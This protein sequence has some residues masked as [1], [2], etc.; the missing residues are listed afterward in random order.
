MDQL[1]KKAD[2][3]A[4]CFDVDEDTGTGTT[5]S[6]QI[7]TSR[8]LRKIDCRL[9]PLLGFCYFLQ[10]LDKV[11]LGY[12]AL[13]GIRADVGLVG[14]EYSW[15]TSIFY[16]GYFAW[17]F[18]TT[19]IIVRVPLGKYLSLV[20]FAW[21]AVLACHAAC[22][23]YAGFMVARF[24]LGVMEAS[25]APGFSF[26]TGKFYKRE[27]QPLR[28]GIWFL[29]NS[30]AGFFG[31]LIAYGIGHIESTLYSWQ[32]L[33][34]ILGSLTSASGIAMFFLLPD[35]PETAWFLSPTERVVAVERT[36]SAHQKK[37]SNKFQSYQVWEALKDPQSWLLC[38]NMLGTML[39]NSGFTA[40]TGIIIAGFGYS[41]LQ[42]LLY[43]MPGSA[44]QIGLVTITSLCGSYVPNSRCYMLVILALLS[45]I[46]CVLVYTLDDNHRQTKLFGTSI[47]GSFAAGIPIS[48]SMVSSNVCGSTKK[49]T[50]SAM[51]FI[52]YCVGNIISP[53][54][55]LAREEPKYPTG[56]K[57]CLS[58]LSLGVASA[59]G[60]RFYMQYRNSRAVTSAGSYESDGSNTDDDQDK[61][62][63]EIPGYIYLL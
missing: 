42:A 10:L 9:L 39:V 56:I 11:S 53:Q 40:F 23:N 22:H 52:C 61:T 29:G 54:V 8:V 38:L 1:S 6:V 30:F 31:G 14:D 35:G 20:V 17:S 5:E 33:F 18:P 41:G 4:P 48:M 63:R 16:F 46:G 50:V 51:L 25:V 49:T 26:L 12:T 34:I 44:V 15:I 47:M 19:W 3:K 27:E 60:L 2:L 37:G 57:V 21:G 43:Q 58:G 28:H 62:D 55:F 7:D 59:M 36:L 32:Y 45:I 13:L 24:I